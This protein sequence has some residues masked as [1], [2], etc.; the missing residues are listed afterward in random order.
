MGFHLICGLTLSLDQI[1]IYHCFTYTAPN[2]WRLSLIYM[3]T[4]VRHITGNE[5]EDKNIANIW[6]VA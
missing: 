2:H 6:P 5:K 1:S 3:K 4:N